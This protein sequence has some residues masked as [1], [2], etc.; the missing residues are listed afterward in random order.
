MD[1]ASPLSDEVLQQ[2]ERLARRVKRSRSMPYAEA[3]ARCF[4][5]AR[6]AVADALNGVARD[7]A[8][9]PPP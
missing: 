9:I 5:G 8:L 4:R 6:E 3:A 1:R 7:S 2:I